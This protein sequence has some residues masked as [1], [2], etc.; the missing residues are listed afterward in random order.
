[1]EDLVQIDRPGT[2]DFELITPVGRVALQQVM[3]SEWVLWGQNPYLKEHPIK[4]PDDFDTVRWIVDH[5]EVIPRFDRIREAEI[6]LG[7][8]GFVVPRIDRTPFQEM[9][10]ELVG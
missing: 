5:L 3:L 6:E 8:M 10:V 4:T 1:M 2:T 9:L 7:D